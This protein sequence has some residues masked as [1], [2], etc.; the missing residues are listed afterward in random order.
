[1]VTILCCLL[2]LLSVYINDVSMD[3]SGNICLL[4]TY[5]IVLL[6]AICCQCINDVSVVACCY[7]IVLLAAR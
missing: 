1:M 7:Y 5:H 2:L 3:V 4:Y 6:A